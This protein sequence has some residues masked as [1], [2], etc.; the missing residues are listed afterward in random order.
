M[1]GAILIA[2]LALAACA[3]PPAPPEMQAA[4][5]GPV[6]PAPSAETLARSELIV[7]VRWL[8]RP[9]PNDYIMAY[10]RDAWYAD[11]EARVPLSCII[12][13]DGSFACAVVGDDK[14]PQYD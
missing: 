1:R 11:A 8:A 5:F 3:T 14:W 13:A 12:Q 9:D 6:P 10:P 4:H 7:G 2:A